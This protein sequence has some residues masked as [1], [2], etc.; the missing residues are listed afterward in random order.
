MNL[1]QRVGPF[2]YATLH[3]YNAL[4][5]L[6]TAKRSRQIANHDASQLRTFLPFLDHYVSSAHAMAEKLS[7]DYQAYTSK[8]SP[9]PITISFELAVFLGLLSAH[10][11]PMAILDLGSGFSSCVFR[12]Y[13]KETAP[14]SAVVYSVDHS[15]PWLA[16][17]GDF[18]QERGLD[19]RHLLTWEELL[20]AEKPKFDLAL[21]DIG[22]LSMRTQV[23]ERIVSICQPGALLVIDDMHV[24]SYR[25]AILNKLDQRGLG[26]Y[27]L[28]NFTKKRLRYAYLATLPTRHAGREQR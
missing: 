22:D 13:L 17:T 3:S 1:F 12:R 10:T 26:R 4:Y 2:L 21:L 18:L 9:G 24:P 6:L 25:R 5:E 19:R 16:K 23:L 11:R 14:A 20:A 15:A 8:V 7:A 27:S 28:R